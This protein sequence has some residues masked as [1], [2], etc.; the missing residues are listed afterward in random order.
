MLLVLDEDFV[1]CARMCRVALEDVWK[2]GLRFFWK[3]IEVE[4]GLERWFI[5]KSVYCSCRGPEFDS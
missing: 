2:L 5:V 3:I 1:P 4:Q